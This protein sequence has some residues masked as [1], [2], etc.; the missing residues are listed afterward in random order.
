MS[1]NFTLQHASFQLDVLMAR[2]HVLKSTLFN[3]QL[4]AAR[5]CLAGPK[6]PFPP[7]LAYLGRGLIWQQPGSAI[8]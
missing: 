4:P 2:L 1:E 3:V 8:A 5:P 6:H 7:L